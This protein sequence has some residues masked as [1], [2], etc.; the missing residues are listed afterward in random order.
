MEAE[1]LAT[2]IP[3]DPAVVE[4]LKSL[5]VKLDVEFPIFA[6]PKK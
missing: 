3:L 5:A 1:R 2:G 6:H 4:E